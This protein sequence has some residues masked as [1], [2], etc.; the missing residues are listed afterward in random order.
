M[1]EEE[2]GDKLGKKNAERARESDGSVV[3]AALGGARY[4]VAFCNGD[5]QDMDPLSA[6]EGVCCLN[7][8]V[9]REFVGVKKIC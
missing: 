4:R 3:D 6:E 1:V 5:C 8:M 9:S 7:K 2:A